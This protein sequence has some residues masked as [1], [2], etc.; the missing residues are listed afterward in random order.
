MLYEKYTK[1]TIENITKLLGESNTRKPDW[2][3]TETYWVGKYEYSY[4]S[5]CNNEN[6][7][8]DGWLYYFDEDDIEQSIQFLE[9]LRT[10][11]EI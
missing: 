8:F 5:Q 11:E 1:L 4:L 6:I 2:D 9:T 10:I 3:D 7:S